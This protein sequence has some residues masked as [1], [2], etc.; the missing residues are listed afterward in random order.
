MLADREKESTAKV[1]SRVDVEKKKREVKLFAYNLV[2]HFVIY[3][4]DKYGSPIYTIDSPN[5][6]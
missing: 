1:K 3:M 2:S 5:Y 6:D 4:V